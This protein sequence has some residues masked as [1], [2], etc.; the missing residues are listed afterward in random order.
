MN[1][2]ELQA[3]R[4]HEL[5]SFEDTLRRIGI[6]EKDIVPALEKYKADRGWN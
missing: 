1:D 3:M 6:R 5:K 4:E 2:E